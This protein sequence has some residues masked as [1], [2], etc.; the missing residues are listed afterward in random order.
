MA[1]MGEDVEGRALLDDAPGFE[2]DD[3][4]GDGLH[5]SHLV[6]DQQDGQ[7]ELAVDALQQRQDLRRGLGVE[8]RG[9]LVR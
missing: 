4:V 2:H 9:R 8:R 6:R 1:G 7:P 5:D 3:L